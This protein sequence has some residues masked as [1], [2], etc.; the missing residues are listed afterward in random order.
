MEKKAKEKGSE[1][2]C[3]KR[4]S[5]ISFSSSNYYQFV[6]MKSPNNKLG[7]E[8]DKSSSDSNSSSI[9][10]QVN[11]EKYKFVEDPINE[12]S[13]AN[14]VIIKIEYKNC[15]C[16][17]TFY[18]LYNVFIFNKNIKYLFKAKELKSYRD[19]PCSEYIKK[20][21][22]LNIGH[23]LGINPEI[24]IKEFAIAERDCK[25]PCLCFCR[26]E[27]KVKINKDKNICGK[28]V[29]PFSC[30][31]TKYKIYDE[32]HKLKY[33]VDTKCCQTGILCPKNFCGY[34]P[35]VTFDI[36]NEKKEIVGSIKRDPG[37]FKQF[38]HVIDCYQIFF[39]KDASFK[40]KFLLICSVFMIENEIF[41]NKWGNL[42]FCWNNGRSK[43]E[44]ECI[45]CIHRCCT[46]LYSGWLRFRF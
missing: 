19:Y 23:V 30:W 26:H 38:M 7:D 42:D 15:C 43:G 24:N 32:I 20:P 35:E 31:D 16:I 45:N 33:I 12:L 40:D 22:V 27:L 10:S 41:K 11:L 37:G 39:P 6:Y 18:N 4:F 34:L 1:R 46:Q 17:N 36:Y 3:V 25:F 2:V 28:I 5:T 21:F 44:N 13:K 14:D 9:S 29:L 8:S